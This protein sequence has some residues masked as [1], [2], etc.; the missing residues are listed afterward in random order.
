MSHEPVHHIELSD[1]EVNF[2]R[3]RAANDVVQGTIELRKFNDP[4]DPERFSNMRHEA[5]ENIRIA[6]QIIG[7]LPPKRNTV[8]LYELP[9]LVSK[10][11]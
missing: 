11:K 9:A 3:I 1:E 10:A 6:S 5:N 4:S 8:R 7:K 2:I